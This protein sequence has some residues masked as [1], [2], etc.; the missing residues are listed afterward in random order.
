MIREI[1]D[2]CQIVYLDG[3]ETNEA[4]TENED[5]SYTIFIN[6]NLSMAKRLEAIQHAFEHTKEND[7]EKNDVQEIEYKRHVG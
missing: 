5:G 2:N 6:N 4:V 7:F 1:L 3:M